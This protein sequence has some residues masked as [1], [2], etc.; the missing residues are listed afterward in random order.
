VIFGSCFA[1]LAGDPEASAIN[2]KD[3]ADAKHS[4]PSMSSMSSC[5]HLKTTAYVSDHAAAIAHCIKLR[6]LMWHLR[7]M[8]IAL[9]SLVLHSADT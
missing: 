1:L 6:V 8:L 2:L 9:P 3:I 7:G 4:P 5:I